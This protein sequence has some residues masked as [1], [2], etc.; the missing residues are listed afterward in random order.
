M[1]EREEGDRDGEG[2][3][4]F[5][6]AFHKASPPCISGAGEIDEEGIFGWIDIMIQ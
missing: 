2:K 3:D 4:L 5:I 1:S 6:E